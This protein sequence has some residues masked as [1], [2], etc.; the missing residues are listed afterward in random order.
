[1][2][3]I[4]AWLIAAMAILGVILRPWRLPEAIWAGAGALALVFLRILPIKLAIGAVGKG[5][6]VYF[7]L[8]G[9]MLL[10]EVARKQG[11]FD[12]L[13]TLAVSRAGGSPR[14]LMTIVYGV[15]I[16]VTTFMSNDAT[17]VVLTPAVY[18]AARKG[19]VQPL[20]YLFACAFVANA[21]SF[22]LPISNPANLVVYGSRTPALGLWLARFAAP[23]LLAIA[24]TFVALL[25]LERNNVAGKLEDSLGSPKLPRGGLVAAIGVAFTGATLLA[26]SAIG[27]PL[28]ISTFGCAALVFAAVSVYARANPWPAL[29]DISWLV[30]PLVAGLFVIV[31]ALDRTGL[32]AYASAIIRISFQQGG[33]LASAGVGAVIAL[34]CNLA[35]NLPVGLM[36]GATAQAAHAPPALRAMMLVGVDIGPNLSVTGSLATILWLI[37]LRREGVDVSALDFLRLGIVVMPAALILALAAL[38][39]QPW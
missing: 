16:L 34:A 14:R 39:I 12:W 4:A 36:A 17:A 38:V 23:S 11:L 24:A 29:R 28:G 18:A 9:M 33:M 37:A 22:V 27:A 19:R 8:T 31:E 10:S 13:A 26:A 2:Q 25:W 21:A 5:A 30:L 6:D 3:T 15:G 32:L 7:F 20:P 1:M 35:N